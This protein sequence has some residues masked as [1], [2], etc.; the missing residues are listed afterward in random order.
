MKYYTFYRESNDF[1]DILNDTSIKSKIDM[2]ISWKNHLIIGL[3]YDI[4]DQVLGYLVLKYGEDITNLTAK[5]YTPIP[6]I[7][8]VPIRSK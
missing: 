5:D 8:Y 2:K 3:P 7:D 6:N 1:T 4:S